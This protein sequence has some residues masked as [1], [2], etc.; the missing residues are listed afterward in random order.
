MAYRL[1]DG[2]RVRTA[3]RRCASE[4]L[5]TAIVELMEGID[6]DPVKAVHSARKALK[7][8]RSLL[9]LGRGALDP[10]ARRN[11]NDAL[12][13]VARSLGGVRDQDVLIQTLDELAGRFTGQV[14]EASFAA[15][16]GA[17]GG[18]STDKPPHS[19]SP[20]IGQAVEELRAARRRVDEWQLARGGWAALHDGLTREYRRGRSAF[21]VARSEP[22]AENMHAWRKRAKDLWYHL[23]LLR[24][25]A[26]DTLGGQADEAHRLSDLLGDEHDLSVLAEALRS[27][28][29]EIPADV[30][31]VLGLIEYRRRELR[32]EAFFLG[33]RVYAESP[34]A[35]ARRMRRYWKAWRAETR[36]AQSLPPGELAHATRV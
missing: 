7:K 11:E 25:M 17:I 10:Q 32:I 1:R 26:R 33:Q 12:R 2:E 24:P 31:A 4:Q 22:S 6:E 18:A 9:R 34:K 8:D 35:F 36:T 28:T 16:R 19:G 15:I 20:L 3:I 13:Q 23:R 14:P 30:D 21:A 29:P 5:D 27:A